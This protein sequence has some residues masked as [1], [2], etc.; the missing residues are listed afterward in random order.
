M[1]VALNEPQLKG[2]YMRSLLAALILALSLYVPWALKGERFDQE[3]LQTVLTLAGLERAN[4]PITLATVAPASAS[5]G[6]EAWISYGADGNAERIFVYT[7]S[8]MFRCARWPF[9]LRQCRIRLASALVHEAWHFENGRNERD[10]YEAQIAFLMR[11]GAATEHIKAVRLA[12]NRVLAK[13]RRATA[14]AWQ[15]FNSCDGGQQSSLPK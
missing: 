13:E 7:A 2:G 12:Q 14:E 6:I 1:R 3:T 4:L 15:R 10:A 8:D 5:E 9:G 11:N